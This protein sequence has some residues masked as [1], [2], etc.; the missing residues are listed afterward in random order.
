MVAGKMDFSLCECRH[1]AMRLERMSPSEEP[2]SKPA[3]SV[4][5]ASES[6]A[7]F[8]LSALNG[9]FSFFASYLTRLHL[10]PEK[11]N[12]NQREIIRFER[13][14]FSPTAKARNVLTGVTDS[15][16][17][18]EP[19]ALGPFELGTLRRLFVPVLVRNLGV[20]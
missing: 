9:K 8:S 15:K 19:V 11:R 4:P 12:S 5:G 3:I 16:D 7:G 20:C 1:R 17:L 6:A 13:G 10:M 14:Y 18:S 2:T